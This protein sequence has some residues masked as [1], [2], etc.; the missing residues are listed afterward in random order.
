MWIWEAYDAFRRN[1]TGVTPL[2]PENQPPLDQ[3]YPC[4]PAD[5]L[6]LPG[7]NTTRGFQG[8]EGVSERQPAAAG[9]A[10]AKNGSAREVGAAVEGTGTLAGEDKGSGT[11]KQDKD[12]GGGNTPEGEDAERGAEKSDAVAVEAKDGD[13]VM[14]ATA[15]E[16]EKDKE[17]TG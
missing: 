14:N 16:A 3:V 15:S 7:D 13:K 10:L 2:A 11:A 1:V 8:R 4:S 12:G 6:E 5:K 17:G 9:E